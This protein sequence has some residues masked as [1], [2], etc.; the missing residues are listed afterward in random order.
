MPVYLIINQHIAMGFKELANQLDGELRFDHLSKILYATDASAYREIPQA[1]ALPASTNDI[2]ALIH[3][4]RKNK[5]SL[6]IS[7]IRLFIFIFGLTIEYK[8][9]NIKC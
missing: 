9:I 6:I 7:L 3:F 8:T 2:V 5:T 4:A 1:V